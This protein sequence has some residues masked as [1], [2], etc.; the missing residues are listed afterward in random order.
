MAFV[1]QAPPAAEK[2]RVG[3]RTT[4]EPERY[5][6]AADRNRLVKNATALAGGA[7]KRTNVSP[8]RIYSAE[9]WEKNEAKN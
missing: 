2:R 8:P 1:G 3:W 6:Q 5:T 7:E 4:Q 9:K